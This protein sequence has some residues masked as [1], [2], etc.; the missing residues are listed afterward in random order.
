[1][2]VEIRPF[3][4]WKDRRVACDWRTLCPH[5]EISYWNPLFCTSH[6]C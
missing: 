5:V 2:K 6:A 4:K 1:M 3:A